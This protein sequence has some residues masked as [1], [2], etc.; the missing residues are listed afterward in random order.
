MRNPSYK[1]LGTGTREGVEFYAGE[2]DQEAATIARD[3]ADYCEE[4]VVIVRHDGY[5]KRVR[6][7]THPQGPADYV[8]DR[9]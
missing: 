8:N 4:D 1:V 9:A 3:S 5:T 6:P 7:S 2:S